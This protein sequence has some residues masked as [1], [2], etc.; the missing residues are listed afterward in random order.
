M[1]GE[2]VS[3]SGDVF[4][5]DFH[6]GYPIYFDISIRSALHS[7]VLVHSAFSSRFGD[8]RGEMEKRCMA[9]GISCS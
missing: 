4:Y 2:S 3:R 5:L 8:L 6:H 1:S 9:P 7:G